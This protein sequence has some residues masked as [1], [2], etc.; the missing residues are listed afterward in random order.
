MYIPA[1]LSP[2]S[3]SYRITVVDRTQI[4]REKTFQ[5][6]KPFSTTGT[7]TLWALRG[8]WF[9]VDGQSCGNIGPI[10]DIIRCV[11]V[12]SRLSTHRIA[13]V[14]RLA[15]VPDG[16]AVCGVVGEALEVEPIGVVCLARA[17][18]VRLF[19]IT[20]RDPESRTGA[21]R[22]V[23]VIK[24]IVCQGGFYRSINTRCTT[25]RIVEN[26]RMRFK[27][28]WQVHAQAPQYSP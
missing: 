21:A 20:Q 2:N 24:D 14:L 16:N 23:V 12:D 10:I 26:K 28:K 1:Q 8:S 6:R 15:E 17:Q 18:W 22:G 7:S 11:A 5:M 13:K 9:M 27:H 25:L 3:P 19:A 4:V